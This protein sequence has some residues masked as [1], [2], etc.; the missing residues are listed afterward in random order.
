MIKTPNKLAT[1]GTY[2]NITKA[3]NNK[4]TAYII[5]NSERVKGFPLRPGARQGCPLT[6]LL[7]NIDWKS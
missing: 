2:L 4:S 1:E 6:P 7:F 5:L 3:I